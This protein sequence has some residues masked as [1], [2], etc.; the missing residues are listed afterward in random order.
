M[1]KSSWNWEGDQ[2]EADIEKGLTQGQATFC[3]VDYMSSNLRKSPLF[4]KHCG[5]GHL[6]N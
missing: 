3:D 5:L 6:K 2:V 4:L 1:L